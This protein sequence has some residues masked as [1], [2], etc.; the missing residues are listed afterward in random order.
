MRVLVGT[1]TRLG[2]L[3]MVIPRSSQDKNMEA[4]KL[5]CSP[6]LGRGPNRVESK[7]TD[8]SNSVLK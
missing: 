8:I 1:Y 6:V 7:E 2:D 3:R 5:C 4:F